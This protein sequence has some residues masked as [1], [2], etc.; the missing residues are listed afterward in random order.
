MANQKRKGTLREHDVRKHLEGDGWVV[1][2]GAA[3]LGAADLVAMRAGEIR[4]VQVKANVRAGPWANFRRGERATLAAEAIA[5]GASAWLA[6]WPHGA[7]G[8]LRWYAEVDWP[9]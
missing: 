9:T 6:W 8:Q 5:A 3:S 4:L 2:R 1:Y 7:K